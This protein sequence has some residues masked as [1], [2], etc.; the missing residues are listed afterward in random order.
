MGAVERFWGK[1]NENEEW[2]VEACALLMDHVLSPEVVGLAF[3]WLR[4]RRT[5][6]TCSEGMAIERRVRK[7]EDHL[8]SHFQPQEDF[9]PNAYM[10]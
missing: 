2:A 7:M 5:V 4:C 9:L 3:H 6:I 1:T 10:T 8:S